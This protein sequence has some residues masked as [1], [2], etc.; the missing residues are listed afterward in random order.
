[1]RSPLHVPEALTKQIERF[2][3]TLGSGQAVLVKRVPVEPAQAGRCFLNV[4]ECIKE[5]GG[6]VLTGWA[7][8]LWPRTFLEAEQHAIWK[9]VDGRCEDVTPHMTDTHTLFVRD[10]NLSFDSRGFATVVN[11]YENIR[12]DN[13]SKLVSQMIA[14]ATEKQKF[15]LMHKT[16]VDGQVIFNG[17]AKIEED[18]QIL[19]AKF[20]KIAAAVLKKCK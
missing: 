3:E 1:M 8:R 2:V 4:G 6:S 15:E 14:A 5:S 13:K 10:D 16:V 19:H 11:R 17:G 20:M 9:Q 12:R 18:Y 7:V